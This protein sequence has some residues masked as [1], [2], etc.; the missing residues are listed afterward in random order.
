MTS[1]PLHDEI[2]EHVVDGQCPYCGRDEIRR[3]S[4]QYNDYYFDCTICQFS[5]V[6]PKTLVDVVDDGR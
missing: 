6:V 4:G 1:G 5:V 3:G 2:V